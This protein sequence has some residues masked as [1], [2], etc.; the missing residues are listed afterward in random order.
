VRCSVVLVSDVAERWYSCISLPGTGQTDGP[1]KFLHF[2]DTEWE[3]VAPE[4]SL[5]I[6]QCAAAYWRLQR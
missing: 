3:I 5:R 1:T 2:R 6:A 4:G